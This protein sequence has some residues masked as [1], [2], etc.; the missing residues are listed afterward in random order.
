MN[1][2]LPRNVGFCGSLARCST[3]YFDRGLS[4]TLAGW[5]SKGLGRECR[6][7]STTA[8]Q[9]DAALYQ[10]RNAM[11]GTRQRNPLH[12]NQRVFSSRRSAMLV[13]T[14]ASTHSNN[15][16]RVKRIA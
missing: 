7:A 11:R 9:Q 6:G 2:T 3:N 1:V 13:A 15:I 12:G 10:Q 4:S 14:A 8:E 16:A 5:D